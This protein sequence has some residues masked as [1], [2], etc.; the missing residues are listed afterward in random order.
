VLLEYIATVST[1]EIY[2]V[3]SPR[4]DVILDGAAGSRLRH[5][6]RSRRRPGTHFRSKRGDCEYGLF[7]S[8]VIDSFM[9]IVPGDPATRCADGLPPKVEA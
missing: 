7:I 3:F 2:V 9:F 1:A 5:G 8:V 4:D 6:P